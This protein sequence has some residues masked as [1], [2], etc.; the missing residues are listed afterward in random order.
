MTNHTGILLE[1]RGILADIK[2]DTEGHGFTDDA[3]YYIGNKAQDA[4]AKLDAFLAAVPGELQAHIKAA[5]ENVI[6]AVRAGGKTNAVTII[7]A[8]ALLSAAVTKGQRA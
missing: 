7:N 1:V 4:L 5:P 8:A 3:V 2:V 6:L